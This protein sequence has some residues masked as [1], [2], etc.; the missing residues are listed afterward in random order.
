MLQTLIDNFISAVHA[1]SQL[2]E[3]LQCCLLACN[4]STFYCCIMLCTV[5]LDLEP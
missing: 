1:S 4:V 2:L 5:Y 3:V